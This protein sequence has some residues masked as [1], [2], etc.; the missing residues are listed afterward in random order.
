MELNKIYNED[1]LITMGNMS[2][3]LINAT[4]TSPPYGGLRQ[5]HGYCFDFENIAKELYRVTKPGGVV[6]WN[7]GDQTNNGSES[8]T[9]HKQAIYFV[10]GCGFYLH[11]TMIWHKANPM[12]MGSQGRYIQSFE[13]M[14]V[15]SKGKP[16]TFNPLMEKCVSAGKKYKDVKVMGNV[17]NP[18]RELLD[19]PREVPTEKVMDNIWRFGHAAKNYGHSAVFPEELPRRHIMTWTNKGDV[20]YDPFCGSGTT[21]AMALELQRNFIGSEI[22][23]EYC[24][25]IED[26]LKCPMA[27]K[28]LYDKFFA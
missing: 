12:S 5:Y 19:T 18:E 4:I 3:G 24:Q 7:V 11:D 15:F 14:F 1:C 20:V 13:Y 10:E 23:K 25:T 26:R 28:E 27:E 21:P 22:S 17:D 2:D 8:L 6:V 16:T 9:S